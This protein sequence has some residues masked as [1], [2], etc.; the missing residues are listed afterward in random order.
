MQHEEL[1]K[2]GNEMTKHPKGLCSFPSFLSFFLFFSFF[3]LCPTD[4]CLPRPQ[5]NSL[6]WPQKVG[7]RKKRATNLCPLTMCTLRRFMAPW[8]CGASVRSTHSIF[9]ASAVAA[10][11]SRHRKERHERT[12]KEGK[13]GKDQDQGANR[14]DEREERKKKTKGVNWVIWGEQ[15]IS[16][17]TNP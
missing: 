14:E 12:E 3:F 1:A 11:A 5:I 17:P 13:D 10:A 16:S 8:R 7:W 6:Q 4:P 9:F 2:F 15:Q